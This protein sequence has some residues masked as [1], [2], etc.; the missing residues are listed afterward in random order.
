MI[1]RLAADKKTRSRTVEGYLALLVVQFCFGLFPLFVHFAVE[2]GQGFAVRVLAFWRILVGSILFG[3]CAALIHGRRFLLQ[4]RD[5]GRFLLCSFLGI[6]AN[7]LFALE[8]VARTSAT[9]AGTL[10]TMIPVF[11]Y[12][13][14][15]LARQESYRGRRAL[16]IV[17]ALLGALLMIFLRGGGTGGS[18]PVLGGFLILM[19][20]LAYALYLVLSRPLLERYPTLVVIA[21]AFL[22]SLWTLPWLAHGEELWPA[23]VSPG[24][25]RGL[26]YLVA[27]PTVLGYLLNTYALARVSASTTAVFIYCQPFIAGVSGMLW[28]DERPTPVIVAPA[29][30]LFGGIWLVIRRGARIH[31][32]DAENAEPRGEEKTGGGGPEAR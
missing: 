30:L 10:M 28:L 32:G 3:G 24:A 11:T 5:L 26:A 22:L 29:V 18:A 9:Q 2:D 23:A 6:A 27:L 25:I 12:A 8:G 4:R 7:Q 17:V 19:N 14:A 20:C 13:I 15:M 21:W 16:G 31:R 1:P